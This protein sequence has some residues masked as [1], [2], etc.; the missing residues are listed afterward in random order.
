MAKAVVSKSENDKEKDWKFADDADEAMG[1]ETFTY[2]N[3]NCIKRINLS[4]GIAIVRELKGKEMEAVDRLTDGD[5]S[6]LN[7]AMISLSTKFND[8]FITMEEVQ[9]L[10]ARDYNK[11]KIA[12]ASLNFM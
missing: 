10:K 12:C 9:E 7:S 2:E 11:L 6:K 1:I 4:F 5:T 8:K 3:G